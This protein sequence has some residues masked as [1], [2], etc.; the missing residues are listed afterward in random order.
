MGEHVGG[1]TVAK[2][3]GANGRGDAGPTSPI[4]NEQVDTLARK[5]GSSLIEEECKLII[6]RTSRPDE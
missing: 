6:S 2:Y 5:P 4:R 1:A 3:V